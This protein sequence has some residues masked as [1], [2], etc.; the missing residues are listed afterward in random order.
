MKKII[1]TLVFLAMSTVSS[2]AIEM[3]TLPELPD[4]GMLSVTAGVSC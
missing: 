3:P 4:F 2:K 1:T